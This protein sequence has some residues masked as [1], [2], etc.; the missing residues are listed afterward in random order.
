MAQFTAVDLSQLEPPQVVETIDY[1]QILAAMI[2]DLQ[3]RDS[4]FGRPAG[5]RPRL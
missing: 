1:E 2:A 3:A 4:T 5:V